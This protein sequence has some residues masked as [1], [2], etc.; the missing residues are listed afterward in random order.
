MASQYLSVADARE[1]LVGSLAALPAERVALEESLGRV[2]AERV[3]ADVNLPPFSNSS[4]DGYAVRSSDV[5][6]ASLEAP[7]RLKVVGDVA[8][9][10]A[11]LPE[12]GPGSCVRIMTGGPLPA[13]ADC[14]VPVEDTD[15]HGP[16]AGRELPETVQIFRP[17]E[18]GGYVRKAGLDVREGDTVLEPGRRLRPQDMAMLASLGIAQ[19]LVYNR[20]NVAVISTGDELVG[21][22]QAL[23]PGKIRESNGTMVRGLIKQSGGRPIRLPIA[24]DDAGSVKAVLDQAV[25]QCADLIVSS[26][27]V[28]MGAYDFVRTVVEQHGEL[29]FWRVNIR[30]GKPLAFGSYRGVPFVGLP[31]NPVSAWVTFAV[32]V[33]PAMDRLEG[34]RGVERVLVRVKVDEALDSD[35]RESY[36]RARVSRSDDGYHARLTGS[37]DSGVL[38]SLVAANAL[39]I[40]PAGDMHVAIGT[41]LDAWILGE[42]IG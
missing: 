23:G 30:P 9:G 36:L 16:M 26:A 15:D 5:A 17:V 39:L 7:R 12:V 38:S 29:A 13:G 4:M 31:G 32:F 11:H 33:L 34:G 24:K 20:P 22:E 40:V 2:L 3:Q 1:L 28:S 19:P 8:A 18:A 27:G 6:E 14:V 21:V 35:G 25:E 10:R 41:E 42:I 37:Q